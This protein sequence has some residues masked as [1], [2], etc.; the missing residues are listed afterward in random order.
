ML[1]VAAAAGRQVDRAYRWSRRRCDWTEL[2]ASLPTVLYA[3]VRATI[4]VTPLAEP[5]TI[6]TREL[7]HG[8]PINGL[9]DTAGANQQLVPSF[10]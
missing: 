10:Y 4:H 5:Y 7:V 1:D 6:L 8:K 9:N 3:H 2:I